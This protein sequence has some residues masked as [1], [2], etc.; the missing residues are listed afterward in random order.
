MSDWCGQFKL[1]DRKPCEC[2]DACQIRELGDSVYG[3]RLGEVV[4]C[5][6]LLML[7]KVR[8]LSLS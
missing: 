2:V 5:R 1:H 3:D 4:K 8:W 7:L 6:A